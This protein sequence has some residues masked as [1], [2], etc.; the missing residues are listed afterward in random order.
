[1]TIKCSV[2]KQ[3]V[4]IHY[5]KETGNADVLLHTNWLLRCVMAQEMV[6][7]VCCGTGNGC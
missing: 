3:V 7:K 1:M 4:Q 6:V 2:Q 5:G